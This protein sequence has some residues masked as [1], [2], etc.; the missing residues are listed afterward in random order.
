MFAAGD[1]TQG[2]SLSVIRMKSDELIPLGLSYGS[3][4]RG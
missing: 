1:I 2:A 3:Q 4:K